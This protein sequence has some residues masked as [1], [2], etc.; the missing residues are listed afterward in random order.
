MLCTCRDLHG[1]CRPSA[2][3]GRV[4]G[5][6][7]KHDKERRCVPPLEMAFDILVP[8]IGRKI[9]VNS[10]QSKPDQSMGFLASWKLPLSPVIML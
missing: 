8:Q 6:L 10:E 4:I 9:F 5:T 2:F 3:K 7:Y 1:V